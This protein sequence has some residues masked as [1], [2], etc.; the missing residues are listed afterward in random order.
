MSACFSF[1]CLTP[2]TSKLLPLSTMPLL[3]GGGRRAPLCAWGLP[4]AVLGALHW[5]QRLSGTWDSFQ[6][7]SGC[8]RAA[9]LTCQECSRWQAAPSWHWGWMISA[10][11]VAIYDFSSCLYES[12][13]RQPGYPRSSNSAFSWKS[14]SW[15]RITQI[16]LNWISFFNLRDER[17]LLEPGVSN[18]NCHW[19]PVFP[20]WSFQCVLEEVYFMSLFWLSFT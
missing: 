6:A 9:G 10:V 3:C 15:E 19:I 14:L 5:A 7:L 17:I 12:L 16:I 4:R 8:E 20:H 1:P 13:L 11:I 2:G 18:L